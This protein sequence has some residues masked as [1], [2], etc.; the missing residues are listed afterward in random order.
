MSCELCKPGEDNC[1]AGEY[2]EVD[3]GGNTVKDA[4]QVTIQSGDRLPPTQQS[5]RRWKK[6]S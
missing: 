6:L 5:G 3:S 2:I 4:R 1:P